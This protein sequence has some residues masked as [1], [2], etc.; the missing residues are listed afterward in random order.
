[1]GYTQSQRW[2]REEERGWPPPTSCWDGDGGERGKFSTLPVLPPLP[3]CP[4][5]LW[6]EYLRLETVSPLGDSPGLSGACCLFLQEELAFVQQGQGIFRAAEPG[7]GAS[8]F[9][10]HL[11]H[12][13]CETPPGYLSLAPERELACWMVTLP[14]T[15]LLVDL[16]KRSSKASRSQPRFGGSKPCPGLCVHRLV[17]DRFL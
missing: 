8:W 2:D 7:R 4:L 11:G 14:L 10:E 9:L 13:K 5:G 16:Q 6:W 12:A 15:A 17:H 3:F 1:M